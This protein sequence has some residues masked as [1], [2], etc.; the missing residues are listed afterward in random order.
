MKITKSKLKQLIKEELAILAEEGDEDD[1]SEEEYYGS[2]TWE[3]DQDQAIMAGGD[4]ADDGPTVALELT[5]HAA[6]E[7]VK[8]LRDHIASFPGDPALAAA[9]EKLEAA[10][11][12]ESQEPEVPAASAEDIEPPQSKARRGI[13]LPKVTRRSVGRLQ[14]GVR[15]GEWD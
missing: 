1:W 8:V 6:E 9:L 5:Q 12:A 2:R 11:G 13:K 14:K 3:Q 4:W 10:L 7:V 15:T